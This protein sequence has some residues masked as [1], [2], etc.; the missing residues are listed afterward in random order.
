MIKDIIAANDSVTPNSREM[1]VLKEY[2]PSCFHTDGSFDLERFKEFLDDKLTVT[3]EGYELK[4]LGKNYARLLASVDTTTVIVPDEEHNKKPENANSQNIYIS[5]DN[6]DGLKHMMKSYIRQIKCIYIDPPYNTGKD[7]FAYADSFN[8]TVDELSEKLSI[9]EE[10]AQRIIDLTKRGSASHSA[11]LMFMYP[12]LQLARD[13]LKNDGVIFISIDDN[14]IA[15]LRLICDD[16]FGEENHI[17]TIIWNNVTDNNPTNIAVEHEY[18]VAYSKSRESLEPI[19]KSSIDD[20]K[21]IL[22]DKEAE[23]LSLPFD[24][25]AGL[26]DAYTA[27]YSEHKAQLGKLEGYKFIDKG[28]IYAGSRSVHNPGKQGYYYDVIHPVTKKAC[29]PP[30]MGYRFPQESMQKLVDEDRIIYGEDE[31]KIIEIK[32]YVREYTDKLSS[33][34]SMDGRSGANVIRA[35]FDNQNVFKNPKAPA[36]LEKLLSF[37]MSDSDTVVDFFAG[38]STTAHAIMNLNCTDEG[39]RHYILVQLKE[40][41]KPGSEAL[42]AGYA[43]IDQIGMERIIR[44][45]KKIR[46]EHPDTTADLG[47]RHYT[48]SEPSE[49]TLDKLEDFSPEDNG[50]YVGNT[51]LDDFGKPTVLATWLVWDGYGFTASVEQLNFAGY[52]GYYIGKHLYL[53]DEKLSDA[54]IEAIVVK[55]E[56]DGDFNPENVVLFGYSFTWTELE[57]LKTN[58]KRLKDEEKNLRINFDVRY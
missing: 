23:L 58:L 20:L 46:E 44:A 54:A 28:G 31:K 40:P 11:W 35:L 43:T 47:F 10:Q 12:R 50:M 53:I 52:T 13:L 42:N 45:A 6:L 8:F 24:S 4:F 15:N 9:S 48:L 16:I 25:E 55:Y 38:S 33:V 22:L 2:F 36:I 57:S 5:G 7:D 14:E 27:W 32:Q 37:A 3:G 30:L 41:N 34:I 29:M 49:D 17:G 39:N 26:Q 19:W 1:A 21:M 51:V 18:I 56:T